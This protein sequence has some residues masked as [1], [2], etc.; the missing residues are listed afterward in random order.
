MEGCDPISTQET[1]PPVGM[2]AERESTE[3]Q[4]SSSLAL[5][6]VLAFCRSSAR[7]LSTNHTGPFGKGVCS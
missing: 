6:L 5:A 4:P 3:G 1:R 7:N 2:V